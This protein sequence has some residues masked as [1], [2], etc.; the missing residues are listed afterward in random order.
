MEVEY[1][2][3]FFCTHSYEPTRLS[4]KYLFVIL[5]CDRA[6]YFS[7]SLIGSS[8]S[9][10]VVPSNRFVKLPICCCSF[11]SHAV[12]DIFFIKEKA[13]FEVIHK[14][15]G[16]MS[17]LNWSAVCGLKR[18]VKRDWPQPCAFYVPRITFSSLFRLDLDF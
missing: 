3:Y 17:A 1:K 2:K 4:L 13:E 14:E 10:W 18:K 7:L 16:I 8:V 6:A 12:A 5:L 9:L 15:W 11:G